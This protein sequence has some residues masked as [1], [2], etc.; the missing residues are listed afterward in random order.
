MIQRDMKWTLTACNQY[1]QRFHAARELGLQM[2]DARGL[3]HAQ[4]EELLRYRWL[5]G[6]MSAMY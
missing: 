3:T 6:D 4:T 5:A 2:A 1:N